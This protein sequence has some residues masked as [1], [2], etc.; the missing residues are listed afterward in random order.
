MERLAAIGAHRGDGL[1]DVLTGLRSTGR[2]GALAAVVAGAPDRDL[3]AIARL[4]SH[5]GLVTV[6]RFEPSSYDPT[7]RW[8]P[9]APAP[10]SGALVRVTGSRPFPV[11][12]N[13]RTPS[14]T[15]V[16]LPKSRSPA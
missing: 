8:L 3:D 11:A 2:G 5:F 16:S 6:V 10:P 1:L 4:R 14:W 15:G 13:A 9:D 7:A 12:W